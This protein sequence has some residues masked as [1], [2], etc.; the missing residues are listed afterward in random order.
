MFCR[1]SRFI[2]FSIGSL[3][4]FAWMHYRRGDHLNC[5]RSSQIGYEGG[6]GHGHGHW[7]PHGRSAH[8][9]HHHHHQQQQQL[10]SHQGTDGSR[11]DANVGQR[12]PLQAVAEASGRLPVDGEFD[13]LR[14]MS[15]NAEETVS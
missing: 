12:E 5:R 7:Y 15:R 6:N 8:F 2:W 14:E 10:G 3:A 9:D 11:I 1:P 4:T 13:R